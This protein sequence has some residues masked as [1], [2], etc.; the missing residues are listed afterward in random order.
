MIV[1]FFITSADSGTFVLGMLTTNGSLNPSN[2]VKFT[3]GIIISA[4]AAVLLISGGI[5]GLETAMIIA[6]LPFTFIMLA[7]IVSLLKSLQT[8]HEILQ[9]DKLNNQAERRRLREEREKIKKEKKIS[10]QEKNNH[11]NQKAVPKWAAFFLRIYTICFFHPIKIK[12]ERPLSKKP[13]FD[14][15]YLT[16]IGNPKA[17]SAASIV[18]SPRV[19]WA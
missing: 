16:W 2:S 19:G 17:T 5:G 3:W 13:L 12:K 6:A 9:A 18:I 8:E 11:F 14:S 15:F 10:A 7:M 1:S 4:A